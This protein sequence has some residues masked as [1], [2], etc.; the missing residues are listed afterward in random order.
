MHERRLVNRERIQR[1]RVNI[2]NKRLEAERDEL[3]QMIESV[4]AEMTSVGEGGKNH[5]SVAAAATLR[6]NN[7]F[8]EQAAQA[9][10]LAE[11]ENLLHAKEKELANLR[12]KKLRR[13]EL[14]TEMAWFVNDLASRS[15]DNGLP[16]PRGLQQRPY[17]FHPAGGNSAGDESTREGSAVDFSFLKQQKAAPPPYELDS[18]TEARFSEMQKTMLRGPNASSGM[19]LLTAGQPPSPEDGD[20]AADHSRY[21]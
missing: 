4:E 19:E 3:A 10:V 12:T 14:E 2:R 9:D 13:Q 18:V 21:R 5:L 8:R 20:D 16:L 17:Y 7:I 6:M 1:R 15:L 11:K